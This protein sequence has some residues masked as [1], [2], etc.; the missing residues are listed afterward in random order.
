LYAETLTV[1]K[2][3]PDNDLPAATPITKAEITVK[4]PVNGAIPDTTTDGACNF[5]IDTVSWSPKDSPFLGNTVYTA[6]V[7]LTANDHYIFNE[8]NKATVNGKNADVSNNTGKTVT[9]SYTFPATNEKTV[10]GIAIKNQPI[11]LTYTHDDPLDLTGLVVTLTYDDKTT[12]D[13]AASRFADT[14]IT[15]N[16][17][18][19]NS[20]VCS[21]NNSQP[22]VITY[23]KLPPKV[24]EKP[25]IVKPKVVRFT[26]DPIP[27]QT[28]TGNP[29]TPDKDIWVKDGT[30]ILTQTTDYTVSYANNTNSG[31]ATVT[32]IGVGNYAGSSGSADFAI[33]SGPMNV[34]IF[35]TAPLNGEAPSTTV[36]GADKFNVDSVSWSPTHNPFQ[37]NVVYTATIKLT[38]KNGYTFTGINSATINGENAAISHNT[39]ASLLL[40]YTFPQT[41]SEPPV[42]IWVPDTAKAVIGHGYDINGHFAYSP[43]I[44]SAVLDLDKLQ[45]EQRV[46]EDPNLRYGEFE[47]ITGKNI[48]EYTSSII[49]NLSYSVNASLKKVASFFEEIGANFSKERTGKG[50]FTFTTSTSR[51]VKG[52]YYIKDESNLEAFFT[53]SFKDDLRTMKPDQ[54]IEKYGTHVMLGAVMGARVDYNLSARRKEENNIA[55]L[56]A[57][58][59]AKAEATYKGVTAGT[60]YSASLEAMFKQYYYIATLETKTRVFGGKVEYG[61]YIQNK[62][63]YDNWIESIEG[64][65]IWIDYYPNSLVPISDLVTDKSL[66]D[67]IAKAIINYCKGKETIVAPFRSILTKVGPT[68]LTSAIEL[69]KKN[70]GGTWNINSPFDITELKSVGYTTFRITLTCRITRRTTIAHEFLGQIS[71]SDGVEIGH[72]AR[73]VPKNNQTESF[74]IDIW[75]DIDSRL[76]SL[77]VKLTVPNGGDGKDYLAEDVIITIEAL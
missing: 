35:I 36:S 28:Y 48:N 55:N 64:N 3:S 11:T 73:T 45:D 74:S 14:N 58:A 62:S 66:S 69:N 27:A 53:Q 63:D 39:G 30:T 9:L 77:T 19:G 57:Y 29:I 21:K 15:A 71:R 13:V 49:A 34:S 40:S 60:D 5:T 24:T 18:Q 47:T 75:P 38:A 76:N 59:K 10:K 52:A 44:K 65:E 23:G 56:G 67:E 32:I 20:L 41:P 68:T 51:I 7:T 1:S 42:H 46:K 22:V 16:P 54:L 37:G 6:T 72:L 31:T 26:V 61:Q 50:E 43:D 25:L 2:N 4:A 17:S 33:I 70:G 8:L 12:E